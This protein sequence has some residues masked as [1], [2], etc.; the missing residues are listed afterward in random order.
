[1]EMVLGADLTARQAYELIIPALVDTGYEAFY[2]PLVD[3]LTVALVNQSGEDAKPLTLQPCVGI[4]GCVPSP[5]V[6]SHRLQHLLKRDLPSVI[7]ESETSP[8]NDPA[9]V[10]VSRDMRDM[11]T[12]VRLDRNDRSDARGVLCRP[13]T[14]RE[15]LGDALTDRPVLVWW[16]D[17]DDGLPQVYHEWAD[18][19][20]GVLER[21]TLQQS[22]DSAATILDVPSFEVT[23]TQVMA[24]KNFRYAGSS[25]FGIGS[26][27]LPSALLPV[28]LVLHEPNLRLSPPPSENAYPEPFVTTP[29]LWSTWTPFRLLPPIPCNLSLSCGQSCPLCTMLTHAW[30]LSSC[31]RYT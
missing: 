6:V 5:A 29:S 17:D 10:D 23:P 24:F 25:Y 2:E 4:P 18:R 21:Y 7:P 26:G 28:N 3:F 15:R 19:Q 1:M 31:P 13:H 8:S 16:A 27:L 9:L 11:I 12:E 20:R 22:V 14:S 30:N